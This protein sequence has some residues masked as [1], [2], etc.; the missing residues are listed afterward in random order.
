[1]NKFSWSPQLHLSA[2]SNPT[3]SYWTIPVLPPIS[4]EPTDQTFQQQI[5]WSWHSAQL[6]L[7]IPLKHCIIC[8]PQTM[9]VYKVILP[10]W[11]IWQSLYYVLR[12]SLSK[13]PLWIF[14]IFNFP[15]GPH[16]PESSSI[17]GDFASLVKVVRTSLTFCLLHNLYFYSPYDF[18]LT[19]LSRKKRYRR[20][21]I[22]PTIEFIGPSSKITRPL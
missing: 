6:V 18:V 3:S 15:Q 5:L 7:P 2:S 22:I 19:L 12:T 17:K 11:A 8:K 4:C 9:M 13:F 21:K 10:L 14:K 1:M 16:L 20:G